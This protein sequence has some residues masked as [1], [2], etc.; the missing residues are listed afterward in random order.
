MKTAAVS[1]AV[2]VAL[3]SCNG[4]SFIAEQIDSICRQT[5]PAFEIVLHDDAS[6]DDTVAVA[7]AAWRRCQEEGLAVPA[8]RLVVHPRRL[9][10]AANFAGALA[11][12]DGALVALCDQDDRWHVDRLAFA[13]AAFDAD[14]EA[15]LLHGNAR[16]VDA[17]GKPLGIDLFQALEVAETEL[18]ALEQGRALEVLLDR[19]LVTG[20]TTMLRRELLHSALPVPAHWVH[21]EWLAAVAAAS[22][23]LRVT[24]RSLIDYRQH[25]NNQIGAQQERWG[26]ALRRLV[27]PRGDFLAY[28]LE[29]ARELLARL[30]TMQP[31]PSAGV[32]ALVEAK[33]AHHAVRAAL[34]GNRLLRLWPAL[35]EWRTGRYHRFGRGI[36][37]LAKDLLEGP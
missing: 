27:R 21:D 2:S 22:R 30:R 12:C 31:P 18:A 7:E 15:F 14:P 24:R 9:G 35:R 34:P 16:L 25:G 8:L 26:V 28:R 33:V 29:R 23:G 5:R 36:R 6:T 10:V 1:P 17:A 13:C 19:N 20:A 4:A 11:Q 3:C 37:G 32:V